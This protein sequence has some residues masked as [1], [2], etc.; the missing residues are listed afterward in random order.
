[1]ILYADDSVLLCSNLSTERLKSKC[2]KSFLQLENWINSNR[3]TLN[4]SK[5]NC[6]LFALF[7]NLKNSL[8]MIFVSIPQTVLY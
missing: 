7:S 5:T 8:I 1:M 4:Y 3:L 6:V 2:E